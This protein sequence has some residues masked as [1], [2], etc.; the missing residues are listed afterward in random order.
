MNGKENSPVD[1]TVRDPLTSLDTGCASHTPQ[2]ADA[3][4]LCRASALQPGNRRVVKQASVVH[5]CNPEW[6]SRLPLICTPAELLRLARCS[7]PES[8]SAQGTQLLKMDALCRGQLSTWEVRGGQG[9]AFSKRS[10]PDDA[11]S[12]VRAKEGTG[13]TSLPSSWGIIGS[14]LSQSVRREKGRCCQLAL[15]RAGTALTAACRAPSTHSSGSS[16]RFKLLAF[17]A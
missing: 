14:F 12:G 4:K 6:L 8:S 7:A 3:R 2:P 11:L 16:Q 13:S 15:A 1:Q 9:S 5:F 10:G 17:L